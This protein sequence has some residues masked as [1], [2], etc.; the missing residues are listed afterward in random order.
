[1]KPSTARGRH[2]RTVTILL[3][4]ASLLTLGAGVCAHAQDAPVAAA[5]VVAAEAPPAAGAAGAVTEVVVTGSH[6]RG[7][8]AVGAP[9]TVLGDK[10]FKQTGAV[11]IGDL[12]VNVPQVTM[13]AGSNV[14]NGGGYVARDQNINLRNLSQKGTRTL[15]MVDG[16]RVPNQGNGGCQTDPSI[17]PQLAVDHVD[18]LADGASAVYG[19]DA[20]AGVVNVVLK[21]GFEGA[22]SQVTYGGSADIGNIR[23]AYDQLVGKKWE[24]NGLAGDVTASYEYYDQGHVGGTARPYFTQ[25]FSKYGYDNRMSI[26][27]SRPG[28]VSVGAAQAA[29]GAPAGFSATTGT[30]CNN[31]YSIPTGQNGKGLTWAQI[32]SNPGVGNEVNVFSDGWEAPAQKRQAFT[33][34]FDQELAPWVKVF[35]DTW[36]SNRNSTMHGQSS[37]NSFNVGLPSSYPYYPAGAPAGLQANYDL[38]LEVPDVVETREIASRYDA[39]LSFQLPHDWVAK[40]SYAVSDIHEFDTTTGIVNKNNVIAA[41]GGTVAATAATAS[42]PFIPAYTKPANIPYLNVLCDPTQF[43]CNDPATL[44]YVSGFRDNNEEE[45]VREFNAQADGPLFHIPGGDVKG[46]VGALYTTT[47]YS[48]VGLASNANNATYTNTTIATGSRYVGSVYAQANIPLIGYD[49]SLPLIKKFDVE[50]AVR[51]D[52]YNQFGSTTNP[53]VAV[54]WLMGWGF[55]VKG[56]VGTSFRAPSFQ[57]NANGGASAVNTVATAASNTVGTC[58][59][60]GQPAKAGSIAALIDPNCTQALQYLGGLSLLNSAQSAAAIRPGG[61]TLTPEKGDNLNIGFLFAPRPDDGPFGILSGLSVEATYWRIKITQKLQGY[62][63][64]AAVGNGQLDDPNY[65]PAFLTAANDPLFAQHV[66]ALLSSPYSALPVNV[67]S[68]I[69]FIADGAIRNIGWQ[70][71]DGIDL[72]ANYRWHMDGLGGFETGVVA[73]FNNQN[74]S[75]GGPGQ[76]TIN[77]YTLNNDGRLRYRAHL[78]WGD[79]EEGRSGF[80]AIAFVNYI[81]HFNPTSNPLPPTCFIEGNAACDASG[82]VHFAQY[83]QQYGAITSYVKDVYTLDLAFSYNTGERFKSYM[84]K[85]VN[86]SLNINNVFDKQP[87]FQYAVSPPGGGAPHAFYT[88]TASQELGIAGRTMSVTLTKNW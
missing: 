82:N 25:D 6:I 32:T 46:A 20:V 13:I 88:S 81:P 9:V 18:I 54:D 7:V 29:P 85:N 26:L 69:S 75:N 87:P 31:C 86:I 22:I 84:L 5:A 64:L 2:L 16:M 62:F 53:K 73:T 37:T 70:F 49:N 38:A 80:G 33:L 40:A 58:P 60:V 55:T 47:T 23:R 45:V 3:G 42:T 79:N 35:A 8:Q 52:H 61:V 21:R 56:S 51:Y 72:N 44:A 27:N 1:M 14:I 15:L 48:N 39:G 30:T 57:E 43:S 4:S 10:E 12:L 34:T 71:V 17:I 76:K 28:I 19:S 66:Q 50:A 63:G 78:G 36:Y 24:I 11:T 65:A 77:Y 83:T 59:V 41:V 67:G 68:N 74:L